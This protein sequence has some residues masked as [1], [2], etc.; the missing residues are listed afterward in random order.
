MF[1][2]KVSSIVTNIKSNAELI[3]VGVHA[4]PEM[5]Y[6]KWFKMNIFFSNSKRKS[7]QFYFVR[8][9]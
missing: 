3:H 9:S 4:F 8:T 1:D 6:R 2:I 5:V 7:S